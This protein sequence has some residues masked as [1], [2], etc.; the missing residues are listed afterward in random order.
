[1]LHDREGVV[2]EMVLIALFKAILGLILDRVSPPVKKALQEGMNNVKAENSVDTAVL[3][4]F[5]KKWTE[6]N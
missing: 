3:D 2:L 6:G 5:D 4:V 1:L